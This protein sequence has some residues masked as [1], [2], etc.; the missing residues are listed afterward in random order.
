MQKK[1]SVSKK[2]KTINNNKKTQKSKNKRIGFVMSG[3]GSIVARDISITDW[4]QLFALDHIE[5]IC[6]QKDLNASQQAYLTDNPND[7]RFFGN[8]INDFADT[9][10]LINH[11]DFIISI[12]SSVAHLAAIQG[13]AKDQNQPFIYLLLPHYPSFRWS[14]KTNKTNWYPSMSIIRQTQQGKW[15]PVLE[16][17]LTLLKE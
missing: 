5:W 6:L 2:K 8:E 10:C 4:Q 15:Q 16:K 12:D 13:Q 14:L 9:A 17:L 1:K 11:C 7:F 3:S